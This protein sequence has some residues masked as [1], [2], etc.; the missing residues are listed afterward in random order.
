MIMVFVLLPDNTW[1][2]DWG[3]SPIHGGHMAKL[4]AAIIGAGN[5]SEYHTN[6]YLAEDGLEVMK[7]LDAI[8]E[9]ARTKKEVYIH[10]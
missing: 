1:I 4:R 2:G 7:I 9:S 6:G 3:E 8:Y 10:D 5:I